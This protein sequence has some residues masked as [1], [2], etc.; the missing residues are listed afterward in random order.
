LLKSNSKGIKV[1]ALFDKNIDESEDS[2]FKE[3]GLAEVISDYNEMFDQNFNIPT[4]ALFKQD[5]SKRL[6]HKG[7]YR[8]LKEEEKI[9]IVVVVNQLL[10]GYDS[11]WINTLYLD[12]TMVY[13]NII[14][15]FSRTNR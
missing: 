14:Q 1:T 9:H 13:A 15:A 6:A 5:L 11:K 10:T 8:R 4:H 7:A 3:D 12:K 2:I